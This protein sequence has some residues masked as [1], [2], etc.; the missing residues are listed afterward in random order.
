LR[1]QLQRADIE[2]EQRSV[3]QDL[4]IHRRW[5][6][7][8]RGDADKVARAGVADHN[9]ASIRSSHIHAEQPGENQAAA[10]LIGF[11]VQASASREINWESVVCQGITQCGRECRKHT[12]GKRCINHRCGESLLAGHGCSYLLHDAARQY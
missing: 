3:G 12:L 1:T 6:T 4:H 5:P 7:D 8:D 10:R 9:L 11:I 2:H